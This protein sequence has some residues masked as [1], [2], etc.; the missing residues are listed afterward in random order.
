[1][2]LEEEFEQLAIA[3]PVGIEEDLD[4]LG[5]ALMVA[6]GGVGH[7]AAGIADPRLFDAGQLANKVLHT[8]E[9]AT[10]QDGPFGLGH[11]TV[12]LFCVRPRWAPEPSS[13]RSMIFLIAGP[14][15]KLMAMRL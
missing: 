4:R 14:A 8:P 12:S 9:A 3:D 13:G 15:P 11:A 7:V 1:M 5:M 10:G 6:I 2:D